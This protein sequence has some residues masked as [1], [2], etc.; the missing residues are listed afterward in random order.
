MF[1]LNLVE[2]CDIY[3]CF[4]LKIRAIVLQNEQF[5]IVMGIIKSPKLRP[6]RI[7]GFFQFILNTAENYATYCFQRANKGE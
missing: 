3:P 4:P 2:N 6:R 5:S 7:I 1:I